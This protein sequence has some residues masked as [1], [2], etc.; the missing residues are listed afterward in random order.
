VDTDDQG[1][2]GH[3]V[4]GPPDHPVD[5]H[6]PAEQRQALEADDVPVAAPGEPTGRDLA[7]CCRLAAA[8]DQREDDRAS[9]AGSGPRAC[10]QVAVDQ[11]SSKGAS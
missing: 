2:P 1:D 11:A 10:Y 4:L 8:V 7:A 5:Q 6:Q 3:R 9:I